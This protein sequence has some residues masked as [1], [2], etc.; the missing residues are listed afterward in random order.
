MNYEPHC[1]MAWASQVAGSDD[2]GAYASRTV[3]QALEDINRSR[4]ALAEIE[5][6]PRPLDDWSEMRKNV[7]E[8]IVRRRILEAQSVRDMRSVVQKAQKNE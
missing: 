6:L 1:V 4:E 8:Y 7:H 2:M 5:S 3:E